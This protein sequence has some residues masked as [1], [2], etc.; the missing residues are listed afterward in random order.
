M[1]HRERGGREGDSPSR[2]LRPGTRAGHRPPASRDA[3]R[4]KKRRRKRRPFLTLRIHVNQALAA[5]EA[6]VKAAAA[7]AV[8]MYSWNLAI[9]PL[10]TVK[11]MAQ[12]LS[13]TRPV[14]RAVAV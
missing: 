7:A 3:A 10:L 13:T 4:L 6:L 9:C 2:L 11:A 1:V 5:S 14:L 8:S 12:S